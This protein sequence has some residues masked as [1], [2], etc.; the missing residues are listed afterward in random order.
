MNDMEEVKG[1]ES[2]RERYGDGVTREIWGRG[3]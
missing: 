1:S 3:C 2:E